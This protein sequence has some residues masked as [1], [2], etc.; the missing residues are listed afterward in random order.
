MSV[1][2]G[3]GRL[4]DTTALRI[5]VLGWSDSQITVDGS[6][7][8]CHIIA[9][10][11]GRV[12]GCG[13]AATSS[14]PGSTGQATRVYGVAVDPDFQGRGLGGRILEQLL[15][16]AARTGSPAVWANARE[17]AL[18]FYLDRGF[19]ASGDPFTDPLS[20]LTDYRIVRQLD[21]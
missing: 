4:L 14:L 10:V 2:I 11:G 19:Q 18:P 17:S 3:R 21:S 6:G 13:S 12:V 7:D 20:G 15:A 5:G 1:R 8:A 16:R 9:S